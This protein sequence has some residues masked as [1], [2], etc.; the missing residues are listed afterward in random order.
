MTLTMTS[1]TLEQ[2]VKYVLLLMNK[3]KNRFNNITHSEFRRSDQGHRDLISQS[4]VT[5]INESPCTIEQDVTWPWN[6]EGHW[7]TLNSDP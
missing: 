7:V 2:K 5:L 4:H 6:T 3:N 1:M